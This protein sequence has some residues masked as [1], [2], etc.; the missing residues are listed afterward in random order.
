[1]IKA[2]YKQMLILFKKKKKIGTS[3]N[4]INIFRLQGL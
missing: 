4:Y 1:M 2:T 3:V